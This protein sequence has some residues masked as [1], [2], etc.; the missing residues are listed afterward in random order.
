MAST[1][2]AGGISPTRGRRAT[3]TRVAA[4]RS[5]IN[6]PLFVVVAILVACSGPTAATGTPPDADAGGQLDVFDSVSTGG[7]EGILAT[8]DLGVGTNRVAFLLLTPQSLVTV[9]EVTVT[10]HRVTE[11]GTVS[12]TPVQT[13]SA[14]FHLWPFGTR[15]NYA[16]NL[17]FDTPGTWFIEAT[18]ADIGDGSPGSVRIPLHV[19]SETMTP[20]VGDL[21][22]LDRPN[23]TISDVGN[24]Q[25]LTTWSR[26]DPDLYQLR[27]ADAVATGRPSLVVFAS[28]ALCTSATC[29]PQVETVAELKNAYRDRVNFVH[30]EVYDNPLEIQGDLSR[31]RYA[32]TVIAWGLTKIAGYR[33]ESWVF[34]LDSDGRVAARYEGFAAA[35]ELVEGLRR[36]LG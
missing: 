14:R 27:I 8:T 20:F 10:L 17:D 6:L 19:G 33:N 25:E 32:D 28:P 26:P 15:G 3:S 9:P 2:R 35:D 31:A 1:F 13:I 34:I 24:L 23:K 30:V 4:W 29:G 22:P 36:V 16:A 18:V 7:V 12:E 21:P 11:A 5:L